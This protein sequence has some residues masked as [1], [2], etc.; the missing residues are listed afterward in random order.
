MSLF[1]RRHLDQHP[2]PGQHQPADPPLQ[3]PQEQRGVLGEE[4]CLQHWLWCWISVQLRV[5]T[6]N[7]KYFIFIAARKSGC[8]ESVDQVVVKEGVQKNLT[9]SCIYNIFECDHNLFAN[10]FKTFLAFL[11]ASSQRVLSSAI[12]SP[13]THSYFYFRNSSVSARNRVDS[14]PSR[15]PPVTLRLMRSPCPVSAPVLI[16]IDVLNIILITE[17]C[18]VECTTMMM[19]A[20]T[21]DT[22]CKNRSCLPIPVLWCCQRRRPLSGPDWSSYVKTASNAHENAQLWH[23]TPNNNKILCL[24]GGV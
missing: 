6:S 13:I 16:I 23:S 15:S 11:H 14:S 22:A 3:V 8:D 2:V 20:R 1:P 5:L 12:L 17:W 10:F 9:I 19:F 7:C 24:I 18:L 4:T 21:V